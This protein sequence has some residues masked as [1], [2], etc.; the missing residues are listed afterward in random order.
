VDLPFEREF[1]WVELQKALMIKIKI[2]IEYGDYT[3]TNLQA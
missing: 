3:D 2:N 1:F